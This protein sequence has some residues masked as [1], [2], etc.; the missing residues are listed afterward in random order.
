MTEVTVS[1]AILFFKKCGGVLRT[2]E[3]L[4]LGINSK[5]LYA[6]EKK[7]DIEKIDRGLY[8]LI[9]HTLE[10]T[11]SDLILITKRLPKAVVCLISALAFHELT[12]QIP[13]FIHIAYQQGWRQPKIQYPPLK[14]YRY[15]K[16]SFEAGIEFH[17]FDKVRIAVYSPAKTVVDC[18]KF[19]NKIGIDVAVEALR[20]YW[21]QDKQA[22]VTELL[23][24]AR[25]CRVVKII[26]P[27]IESL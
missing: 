25:I 8:R 21:H 19:R 10:A 9:D 22:N 20:S 14:V 15:S 5:T 13:R 4:A 16:T 23:K 18:F 24:Y 27:Y 2:S 7:G 26:T 6:M 1:K 3:A 17:T 12:T 11:Y